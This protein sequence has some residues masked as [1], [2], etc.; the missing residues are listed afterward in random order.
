[1]INPILHKYAAMLLAL[2]VLT[3]FLQVQTV[4]ACEMMDQVFLNECC[5]GDKQP[6]ADLDCG[7]L[8]SSGQQNCCEISV[9][10][11]TNPDEAQAVILEA[12]YQVRSDVDP[13]G[14]NSTII[15][16]TPEFYTSATTYDWPVARTFPTTA[17]QTYLL[18]Q[19]LRI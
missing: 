12:P 11:N 1:M 5:C 2:T 16:D 17:Q 19:R 10:I 9:E 7:D 3:G 4:Y 8:L 14:A 15:P 18:T 6:C 13:P